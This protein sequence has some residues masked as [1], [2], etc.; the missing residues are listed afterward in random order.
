MC[1]PAAAAALV[2]AGMS[3]MGTGVAALSAKAQGD[4]Q[5]KIAERNAA[6]E[7]EASQQDQQNTR[8]EALAHY[9]NVAKLK[10]EQIVGAA[11]N[12][13]GVDFGTAADTLADTDM[14]AR[15]DTKRIYSQAGQKMKGRSIAASNYMGEASA[16]RSAGTAALVGGA[17]NMGSTILGGVSQY[18][19]L[20]A[21]SK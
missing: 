21:G 10:G 2:A 14:L 9:R 19:K 4:Y 6:M 3:A 13:V 20:K 15:E 18:K 8:E 12:G 11:A 7:R 17:F 5:A 16:Q 1:I